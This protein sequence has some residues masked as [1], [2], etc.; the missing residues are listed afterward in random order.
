M[1]WD[2]VVCPRQF[3]MLVMVLGG[4]AQAVSLLARCGAC[5]DKA[6]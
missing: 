1:G 2:K 4:E 5:R 6:S 3:E